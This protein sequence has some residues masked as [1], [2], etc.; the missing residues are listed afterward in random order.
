MVTEQPVR[1]QIQ[2]TDPQGQQPIT[3]HFAS[4]TG[5]EKLSPKYTYSHY[6]NTHTHTYIHIRRGCRPINLLR[7]YADRK[8]FLALCSLPF[9]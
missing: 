5:E 1:R 9:R 4:S 7:E 6:M 8:S 3:L 2:R